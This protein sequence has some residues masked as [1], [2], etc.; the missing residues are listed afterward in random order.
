MQRSAEVLNLC[1]CYLKMGT[2]GMTG[3]ILISVSGWVQT[4]GTEVNVDAG[5]VLPGW[6]GTLISLAL[7]LIWLSAVALWIYLL[8]YCATRDPERGI[9][10]WLLILMPP[11]GTVL[12]LVFR[13]LP[14]Q[15]VRPPKFLRSLGR[16]KEIRR[17]ETAARQIG[18]AHQFVQWG[19]ALRETGRDEPA[20]GAYAGALEREPDNIQALWGSAQVSLRTEQYAEA[21]ATLA[22]VLEQDPEYKF[23]DVSLAMGRALIGSGQTDRALERLTDHIRRWRH[24]EAVYLLATLQVDSGDTESARTNLNE[25]IMDVEASP[26]DIAR[27]HRIW[28]SRARRLLSRLP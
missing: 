23:G 19:D 14:Q 10:L 4:A 24:P 20:A 7:T 16:G 27:R 12:Y 21:E 3:Q 5:S 28:R 8:W 25:L 6:L 22:R 17:L 9:F 1:Q 13:W 2:D 18:N 15:R 26:K 11:L